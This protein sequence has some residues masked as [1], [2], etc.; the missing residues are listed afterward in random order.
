MTYQLQTADAVLYNPNTITTDATALSGLL[1]YS[2]YAATTEETA[3][4]PAEADF[5]ADV[6]ITVAVAKSSSSSY[7]FHAV[8]DAVQSS[9]NFYLRAII[10]NRPFAYISL[11]EILQEFV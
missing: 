6:T 4:T 2:S 3:M 1:S 11:S 7:Y 10:F 8:A 9:K 5:S